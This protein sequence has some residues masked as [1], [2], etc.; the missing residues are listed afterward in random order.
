MRDAD[1]RVIANE[2]IGKDVT[3]R[4]R[5]EEALR[6]AHEE[7]EKRVQERTAELKSMND[8]LRESEHRYR[9]VVEDQLE[10]IIR[11]HGDGVLTFANECVL[12]LLQVE[13]RRTV[14]A[15]ASCRRRRGGSRGA[16]ETA[17]ERLD[18]VTR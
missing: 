8:Q 10:F 2:G 14:S 7:L 5:A 3:Q 1:G 11:W 13:P 18:R 9:S 6:R 16:E 4:N 17:G 15:P 12:R